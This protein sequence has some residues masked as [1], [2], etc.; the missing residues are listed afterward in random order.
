M[1][2]KALCDYAQKQEDSGIPDGWQEQGQAVQPGPRVCARGRGP[3][4]LGQ[5]T[6]RGPVRT[7][8]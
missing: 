2:I 6:R 1:L 4:R 7:M 8:Y 5:R 3:G